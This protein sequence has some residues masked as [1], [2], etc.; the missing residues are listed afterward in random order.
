LASFL[1]ETAAWALEG[2]VLIRWAVLLGF[3]ARKW[4]KSPFAFGG[5]SRKY[6]RNTAKQ[7]VLECL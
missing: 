2:S 3:F 4:W 7:A 6:S 1:A 5:K